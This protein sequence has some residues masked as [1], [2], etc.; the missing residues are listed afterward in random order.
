MNH[1]DRLQGRD[2]ARTYVQN[3]EL[4]RAAA[5]AGVAQQGGKTQRQQQAPRVDTVTLSANARAVAAAREAVQAAPDVRADKVAE[6]KQ[7]VTDGTYTVN[8]SVLA[9]KLLQGG[10]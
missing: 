5:A 2:A 4:S 6:I 7:R 8:S 1:I 3:A 10:N 9:R